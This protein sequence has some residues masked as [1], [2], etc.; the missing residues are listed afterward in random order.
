MGRHTMGTSFIT[1]ILCSKRGWIIAFHQTRLC[2]YSCM[3]DT[4]WRCCQRCFTHYQPGNVTVIS[5]IC[6]FLNHIS[7]QQIIY[8]KTVLICISE[9]FDLD[10]TTSLSWG[11]GLARQ[12]AITGTT[13]VDHDPQAVCSA[14]LWNLRRLYCN[15]YTFHFVSITSVLLLYST[16]QAR[17]LHAGLLVIVHYRWISPVSFKVT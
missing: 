16:F 1:R 4:H 6:F 5:K 8:I 14:T 13:K 7:H 9:D 12:Q 11:L 10:K 17:R 2:N 3:F 15:N